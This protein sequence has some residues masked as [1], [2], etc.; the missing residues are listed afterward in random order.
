M[1][2][3]SATSG[4]S[5]VA[6]GVVVGSVV[7]VVVFFDDF[8]DLSVSAFADLPVSVFFADC[9]LTLAFA[10]SVV[11]FDFG[12]WALT[13]VFGASVFTFGDF[14][15]SLGPVGPAADVDAIKNTTRVVMVRNV[16]IRVP[17]AMCL[18][19]MDAG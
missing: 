6:A 18:H 7:V 11:T 13:F 5:A 2:L 19:K 17:P 16:F 3:G 12:A 10:D 4:V 1:A 15:V 8:A 9:V 14:V